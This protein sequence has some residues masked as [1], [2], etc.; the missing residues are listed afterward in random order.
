MLVGPDHVLVEL[1]GEHLSMSQGLYA[2]P[3]VLEKAYKLSQ[4][5]RGIGHV[6]TV[7][8]F[9]R[10]ALVDGIDALRAIETISVLQS[11]DAAIDYAKRLVEARKAER[12]S[13]Q[14]SSG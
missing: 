9:G 14:P 1:F 4:R 10:V 12:A 5:L 11:T 13:S 7:E 3:V 6:E 2:V 8:F